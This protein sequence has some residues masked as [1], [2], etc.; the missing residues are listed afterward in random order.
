MRINKADDQIGKIRKPTTHSE[1]GSVE[2]KINESEN[3]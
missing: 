2:K 3:I 1:W